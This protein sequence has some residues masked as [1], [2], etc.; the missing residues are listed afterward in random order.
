MNS[1]ASGPGLILCSVL[2]LIGGAAIQRLSDPA[3][4]PAEPSPTSK[5]P[6]ITAVSDNPRSVPAAQNSSV[7]LQFDDV[8]ARAD[9]CDKAG[10]PLGFGR[11]ILHWIR[12]A[13]A[14]LLSALLE[15]ERRAFILE[16]DN[17]GGTVTWGLA[18][19]ALDL[20]LIRWAELDRENAVSWA[21]TR[22][23]VPDSA[24]RMPDLAKGHLPWLKLSPEQAL[25]SIRDAGTAASQTALKRAREFLA[26]RHR[27]LDFNAAMS[28]GVDPAVY[29]GMWDSRG[30]EVTKIAQ[31]ALAS[32]GLSQ[33]NLEQVLRWL[34]PRDPRALL[35]VVDEPSLREAI[36]DSAA[37]AIA[38]SNRGIVSGLRLAD[39]FDIPFG[40]FS[41]G[42]ARGGQLM[43]V[44]DQDPEGTVALLSEFK[45]PDNR[46]ILL[47]N[48]FNGASR[49]YA[50]QERLD[51]YLDLPP[52]ERPKMIRMNSIVQMASM[53][54]PRATHQWLLNVARDSLSRTDLHYMNRMVESSAANLASQSSHAVLEA[55]KAQPEGEFRS[56]MVKG[57]IQG[58][59]GHDLPN[60]L[61]LMNELS[62]DARIDVESTVMRQYID[63]EGA[64]AGIA[65]LNEVSD[66][67]QQRKLAMDISAHAGGFGGIPA[68]DAVEVFK[69]FLAEDEQ[70][71]ASASTMIHG[72]AKVEPHS[73]AE[74]ITAH[75]TPDDYSGHIQTIV[76]LW[77]ELDLTAAKNFVQ[78]LEAGR[79]YDSGVT[80]IVRRAIGSDP[81]LALKW[82]ATV[83]DS[84]T[85]QE[86]LQQAVLA[87]ERFATQPGE[88][89]AAI[90]ELHLDPGEEINLL[91]YTDRK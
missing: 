3:V 42:P 35:G 65:L 59:V 17:G 57:A 63:A 41:P 69:A 4:S 13:D 53:K 80:E 28:A 47:S 7:G 52:D 34:A 77:A 6:S 90:A 20:A 85:R 71:L 30:T 74:W 73:A 60:A 11:L 49:E 76:A 58:M 39:D 82:S 67:E 32:Q 70:A 79:A 5:E 68:L 27:Q 36:K 26:A 66:P 12:S 18:S 43:T 33:S 45:N 48:I 51:L 88:A 38:N 14:A 25:A 40:R 16:R 37:N 1:I 56:A 44:M 23:E 89:Q 84:E 22:E 75:G 72:W 78:S 50:L 21:L 83:G 87:I 10:D 2:G 15:P 24:S 62:G 29:A 86:K 9:E 64:A 8:L 31:A 91:E 61:Q 19:G 46:R 81:H 55:I 54:S